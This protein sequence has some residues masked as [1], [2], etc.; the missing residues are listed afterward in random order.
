MEFQQMQFGSVTFVLAETILREL[1][2]KVT[3][4]SVASDFR[5][6]ASG[7]DAQAYAI[8]IDDGGL[9]KRKRDYR[10]SI[11]QDVVWHLNQGFDCQAHGTVARAQNVNPIDLDGINDT[12]SPS[13]VGIS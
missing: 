1:R 11:D 10:Q 13:D 6:H 7:S 4:H 9:R 2:A 3:H 5:N 8:A 12:D